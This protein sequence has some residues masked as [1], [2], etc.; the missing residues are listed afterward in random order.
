MERIKG[1]WNTF[2]CVTTLVV[3]ASAVYHGF[4]E[5]G[6]AQ[7]GYSL[8]DSGNLPGLQPWHAGY[9]SGWQQFQEKNAGFQYPV[10]SV[11]ERRCAMRRF[12]IRVVLYK[13]SAHD[14]GNAYFDRCCFYMR[15]D[16]FLPS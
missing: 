9:K 11:C 2:V 5:G 13:Q 10:L 4:L 7:G 15:E 3:L 12:C 8:A 14:G 6:H 1:A 16:D